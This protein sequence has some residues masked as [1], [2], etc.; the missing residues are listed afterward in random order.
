MFTRT[1]ETQR[2]LLFALPVKICT[3]GRMVLR[4]ISE[5]T[6]QDVQIVVKEKADI[7]DAIKWALVVLRAK[8]SLT[9]KI[10]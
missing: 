8:E 6:I 9:E 1:I 5:K 2:T 10:I 4:V 3:P 7:T